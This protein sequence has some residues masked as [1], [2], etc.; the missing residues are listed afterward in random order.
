MKKNIIFIFSL[1]FAVILIAD[2]AE[3]NKLV[4]GKVLK[5][6]VAN[7][8]IISVILE[9]KNADENVVPEVKLVKEWNGFECVHQQTQLLNSVDDAGQLMRTWKIQLAWQPGADLSGCLFSVTFL[10]LE[11]SHVQLFMN[12]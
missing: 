3:N 5:I 10:G 8:E 6:D 7:K 1:F 2:A 12:Y 9:T 4:P 11:D